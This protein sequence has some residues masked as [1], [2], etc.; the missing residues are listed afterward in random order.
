M[1]ALVSCQGRVPLGGD[2]SIG[3]MGT[4]SSVGG[5][6]ADSGAGGSTV[7]EGVGGTTSPIDDSGSS[8]VENGS[9]PC[10]IL[11]QAGNPCVAAHSTVRALSSAHARPIYQLCKGEY[12]PG[13][14][15]CRGA[16][17]DIGI[18]G[19][20]H[21][22]VAAHDAFCGTSLCTIS[23]I[24][25]QSGYGN[26]LEPAP[27]GGNKSNPD[28]P[29]LASGLKTTIGGQ[30]AYAL[31]FKPGM[32]YRKLIGNATATGDEPETIYMVTSQHELINGCCFD[33]GNAETTARND[34]NG[35]AE[36]VYFGRGVIWGTGVGEGPWVMA[37]LENGLYA[38][39]EN[40]QDQNIS[41]NTPL[42]F[43]FVTAVL[44]GDT[45]EK[46]GRL[47][48]FAL[49]G[50]N[51]MTG[52]LTTLY[53]GPRPMKPGYFSMQKQGS[54]ILSTAGDNSNAGGGRFYEGVMA[55]GAATKET[56]D[57]L[58]ASIIA[59]GYGS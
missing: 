55:T 30:Q 17:I 40:N 34:G 3:G 12:A 29:V 18:V 16:T 43:D 44:V 14:N 52:P 21:A 22:D 37:D 6:T 1:S 59:A 46:N 38:G 45:V 50:G 56:V 8:S 5:A 41:T 13:P 32:G 10:D 48:R 35:T 25:D 33:Y 23:R 2:D 9:L 42:E 54:I 36:A 51:A 57:A 15:S 4:T 58:Q 47:G 49:Y 31:L 39:W 27:A 53:D 19:G 24:Y 11:Q 28:N 7:V 26:D 20:G